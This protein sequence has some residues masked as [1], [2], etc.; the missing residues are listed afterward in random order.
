[1]L[2]ARR[3]EAAWTAF[4]VAFA[5]LGLVTSE[6]EPVCEGPLILRVDDSQPPECPSPVEFLVVLL[7]ALAIAWAVGLGVI[8]AMRGL[9]RSKVASRGFNS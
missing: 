2:R 4:L 6:G 8:L 5:V 9:K 1:M 7:P 3:T